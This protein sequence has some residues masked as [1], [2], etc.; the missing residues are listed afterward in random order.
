MIYYEFF[1]YFWDSP[2]FLGFPLFF[3]T[4]KVSYG[5]TWAFKIYHQLLQFYDF[6]VGDLIEYFSLVFSIAF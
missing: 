2:N 6:D 1:K 4:L 5:E 3:S